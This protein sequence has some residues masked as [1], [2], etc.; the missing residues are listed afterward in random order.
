MRISFLTNFKDII[1]KI[2]NKENFSTV[3]HLPK[4]L[5]KIDRAILVSCVF[6]VALSTLFIWR[7]HWLATT[8]EAPS[9]GGVYTEG[10][11]GEAK[12]LDKHLVRLTNAGLT[13]LDSGGDVKG[14]L[15]ESW[16]VK[17]EGKI[18]EFKLRDGFVSQD[19]ADQLKNKNLWPNIEVDTPSEDIISFKFKQPF[20]PFLYI[21]TKA[22]FPYGPYTIIK[23]EK[24]RVTLSAQENYWR[25]KPNIEKIQLNLYSTYDELYK[26]AKRN[27]ILAYTA[28]AKDDYKMENTGT[29]EYTLPRELVL[30]FNLSK[31]DLQNVDIRRKLRDGQIL[32]KDLTLDLVTSDTGK[33]MAVADSIKN[34]MAGL[35][36]TLNIKKYDN[37]TLQKDII[38]NRKY[39]LLL[40]GLDYGPDPDPYPF[41]HSSQI[42]PD[43]M[44]LSNFSNKKGDK[45]LEEARQTFDFKI[46][47]QKYTDF[48]KILDDEVP[49]I[50]INKEV[51]YFVLS[52]KIKGVDKI[53]GFSESDR[54]LNIDKWYIKSKRV[55]K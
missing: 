51:C 15:A 5:S 23:E 3:T 25:G 18:Y 19:L 55:K 13:R 11:V 29:Y 28:D 8:V 37:I 41:W 10:I 17:D 52:N 21:S 4:A 44:N 20:S 34:R 54:Y 53:Y 2:I 30:F 39:D 40:Y 35:K 48:K 31:S 9:F 1:S 27:D 24:N 12:D 45:L 7:N 38:P 33:N 16:E 49:F 26:E 50:S 14:D 46:R 32:D 6:L 43:G 36:L 22:V 47:E 42:K